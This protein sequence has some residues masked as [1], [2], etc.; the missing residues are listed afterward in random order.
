VLAHKKCSILKDITTPAILIL[1]AK[2]LPAII[3]LTAKKLPEMKRYP[4]SGPLGPNSQLKNCLWLKS[5]AS[6]EISTPQLVTEQMQ[7]KFLS[8]F[9]P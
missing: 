5:D 9:D 4:N 1:T 7:N 6:F 3:I 8:V 2:K